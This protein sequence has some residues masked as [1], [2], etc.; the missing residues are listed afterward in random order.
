MK[1][2]RKVSTLCAVI[3]L[4]AASAAFGAEK[5]KL[6]VGVTPFPHGEIMKVAANILAEKDIELEIREFNDYVQP[7]LALA[8]GSLNANFFQ[9]IPYLNNMVTEQK[10]DLAVA[11]KVHIEPMGI[12]SKKIKSLD[13]LENGATIAVPNDPTNGA[14]ALR[15]LEANGLIKFAEG[16]LITAADVTE[17]P[18]DLKFVELEAAQLPRTLDDATIS[19]INTN[20]AVEAGLNPAKD[21]LAIEGAESPYVNVV[22]VRTADLELPEIKA[23]IEAVN[24][25]QVKEFIDTELTPRGIVSAF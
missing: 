10:L 3:A 13:E 8:D 9:H 23:L 18:K 11:A 20:F 5:T 17:N 2:F 15:V 22:A 4:L 21:A 7:N 25:P 12:Y 6:I 16:E 14:R 1:M 24:S 19:V